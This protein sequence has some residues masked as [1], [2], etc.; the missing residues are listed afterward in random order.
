MC[1]KKL[2]VIGIKGFPASTFPPDIEA[3]QLGIM[4]A[5][6]WQSITPTSVMERSIQVQNWPPGIN[7]LLSQSAMI[8]CEFDD[9]TR[10]IE[11]EG[12]AQ[13]YLRGAL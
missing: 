3:P 2:S 1:S 8:D 6:L 12:W 9:I 5:R 11:E 13:T 10:Q 4:S 7:G